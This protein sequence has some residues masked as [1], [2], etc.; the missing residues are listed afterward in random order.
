MAEARA[1]FRAFLRE[2]RKFPNYNVREYIHRRAK[3]AFHEAASV[4][5]PATVSSLIKQA[6][7]ELELV[8][9]QA[10]VYAL[11]ARRVKNVLELDIASKSKPRPTA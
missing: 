8:K 7:E 4:S 9:R 5:N 10:L 11:Y 2:G 1:L 6:K 3:E